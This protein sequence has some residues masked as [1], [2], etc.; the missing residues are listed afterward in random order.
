[1]NVRR[2]ILDRLASVHWSKV[3]IACVILT[4]L[5][6][7]L[8]APTSA[9]DGKALAEIKQTGKI[10]LGMYLSF[11]G[12]SFKERGNLAGLEVALA[13]IL[14]EELSKELGQ[15]IKPEIV[16]QEWGQIIKVLRDG[17]YHAVLSALIPNSMYDSYNVSYSD[18]YLDTGP[19]ICCQEKD[20][21]P[22]KDVT[23][24][25]S[26]LEGKRVVVINDPAVRRVMRNAGIYVPNDESR[27]DLA[28]AFPKSATEAAIKTTGGTTPLIPVA[29]IIQIDE[30][31]VIYKML[32][33]GEVDAGVI[34]L[35]IIWW[36][37]NDSRRWSKKVHAFSKPVGPY[38]YSAVTC[39]EDSDL[40][41]ALNKAVQRMRKS[42]KY[43][44]ICGKWHGTEIFTWDLT[45]DDFL[46]H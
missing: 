33:E 8:S 24:D 32:A 37:A 31:P 26:S 3:T 17:K 19:V 6:L 1:M 29:E 5:L 12:L 28:K 9:A 35:G 30:M 43:A 36:V 42:P 14:C 25:A 21:K 18:P 4:S 16:D 15:E 34:D 7:G 40:A 45:A 11:E 2:R 44:E 10:R 46:V 20:G 27:T 41:E 38:I 22:S 39:E 13:D 23:A